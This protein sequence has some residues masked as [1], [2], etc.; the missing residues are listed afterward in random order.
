MNE[1]TSLMDR[2][3]VL[4]LDIEVVHLGFFMPAGYVH[5]YQ[6]IAALVPEHITRF[7]ITG[8]NPPAPLLSLLVLLSARLEA[9]V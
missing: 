8:F 2:V 6:T 1:N 5:D 7:E 4:A 9:G 3:V